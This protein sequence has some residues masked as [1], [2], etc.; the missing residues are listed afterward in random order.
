MSVAC[1]AEPP[2]ELMARATALTWHSLKARSMGVA[3]AGQP[4]PAAQRP[5]LADDAGQ[6]QHRNHWRRTPQTR[7][8]QD[9]AEAC[10]VDHGARRGRELRSR[11]APP[12]STACAASL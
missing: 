11:P 10:D 1:T 6:A 3:Q 12:R 9:P 5:D 7:T 4:E 2:G 8:T